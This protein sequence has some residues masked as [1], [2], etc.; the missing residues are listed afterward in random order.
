MA[1]RDVADRRLPRG[2]DLPASIVFDMF[3]V[4]EGRSDLT[5]EVDLVAGADGAPVVRFGSLHVMEGRWC[6][7][8]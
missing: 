4:Q 1:M 7:G 2:G 8:A 3:T 5:L 6:Q